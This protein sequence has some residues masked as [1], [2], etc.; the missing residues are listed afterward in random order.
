MPNTITG[1]TTFVTATAAKSV[2]M[3]TNFSNYRGTILP[4]DPNT[5]AAAT[6]TYD[7][8]SSDYRWNNAYLNNLIFKGATTTDDVSFSI[9]QDVT[10]AT[11]LVKVGDSITRGVVVEGTGLTASGDANAY[12][13]MTT[14]FITVASLD[15]EL[16]TNGGI[17]LLYVSYGEGAFTTPVYSEWGPDESAGPN[18][19]SWDFAWFKQ[20]AGTGVS[21]VTT[22]ISRMRRH[23]ATPS[24][25]ER[26]APSMFNA[27]DLAGDQDTFHYWVAVKNTS[28][29]V[30]TVWK[31]LNVK[32]VAKEIL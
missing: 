15:V 16:K 22:T 7:L 3:N 13:T 26:F 4:I 6:D 25:K 17:V 12:Q 2:E 14:S 29:A 8:G 18:A 19:G 23:D 28:A 20:T 11:L 21:G 10:A 9:D 1:Y 31:S 24:V 30:D 27:F 5:A 32:L